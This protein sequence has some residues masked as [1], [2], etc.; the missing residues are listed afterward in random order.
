MVTPQFLLLLR[1]A[2]LFTSI[3]NQEDYEDFLA[4][5]TNLDWFKNNHSQSFRVM[6]KIVSE[7][8]FKFFRLELEKN[9]ASLGKPELHPWL[10]LKN[11]NWQT[12]AATKAAYI[13]ELNET[14]D[15]IGALSAAFK[16]IH[17]QNGFGL[18]Y[19]RI[20]LTDA[21]ETASYAQKTMATFLND[22]YNDI[23]NGL[24]AGIDK[25][26]YREMRKLLAKLPV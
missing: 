2:D 14:K 26:T 6:D 20:W 7:D 15:S 10:A 23:S 19:D 12:L 25:P 21:W 9:W 3:C 13:E 4:E 22:L 18:S 24:V 16:L 1:L 11:V 8:C 5:P 17:L